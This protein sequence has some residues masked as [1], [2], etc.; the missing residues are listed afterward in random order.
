MI[1]NIV[2]ATL[3][4]SSLSLFAGASQQPASIFDEM[5]YAEVLEMELEVSMDNLLANRRD[6]NNY[7]AKLSFTDKEGQLQSWNTKVSL[8]GKFRRM[9]CA[10]MPPL[11]LKFKKDDLS[12][13]GLSTSNDLKMVTQCVEDE[14]EAKELLLKEYLTYKLYNQITD[15]SYRVQLVKVSYKDA[16]SGNTKNQWAFLIEDTAQMRDRLSA[17]K[18][19]KK[20]GFEIASINADIEKTT[21]VFQY[22]IG[23][24]D[25]G[26]AN[27]RN[28]KII[29][30][31]TEFYSI[32]YD[33][34]FSGIVGAPYARANTALGIKTRND[35]IYLGLDQNLDHLEKQTE[36][37]KAK[38][39]VLFKT[40]REF[41]LL[42]Y[43]ARKDMIAYLE[44]FYADKEPIKTKD[45]YLA[46]R[47][48]K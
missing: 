46:H 25:W 16:V 19:G 36:L 11:K 33:F 5:N 14:E 41:K 10:E 39:A 6:N 44:L 9:K 15:Y 35:R 17:E 40:I 21:A 29:K 26:V 24:H 12:A 45:S 3:M 43:S 18:L 22:L 23:N 42:D 13:A 38:K 27:Q 20:E 4:V 8:R 34:D 2:F 32:P 31:G 48:N 30:K 28:I 1:R 37:F 7:E 47:G